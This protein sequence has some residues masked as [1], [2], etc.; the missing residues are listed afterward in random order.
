M[1]QTYHLG[2]I[3]YPVRYSLSP[4]IHQAALQALGMSGDYRLFAV[5]P[6]PAG[7]DKLA[8][9]LE[10][11]RAGCLHGL[12]VTIPH[13]QTIIPYLD[14]L[15]SLACAIGAV[16][17]VCKRG[18]QVIGFNTDAP[19]FLLDL[20]KKYR[21]LWDDE[22]RHALILGA[23]GAARAVAFALLATGWQVSIA[24]RRHSQAETLCQAM[25][26][27]FSEAFQ[28]IQD[29]EECSWVRHELSFPCRDLRSH[30]MVQAVGLNKLPLSLT[31]P[32]RLIVNA[33]PLG[34]KSYLNQ[35]PLP[36][37]FDFPQGTVV[38]D[39]VYNPLETIL[40]R[41]AKARGAIALSGIG[42]LVE[43]AALS[44][45]LWTGVS[46]PREPMYQA[47]QPSI[48]FSKE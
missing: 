14:S 26:N 12:N 1:E 9:I 5:E 4:T 38:Y 3:G 2:L 25:V 35:S 41:Q 37:S 7:Q 42:M 8:E 17:T 31:P 29:L 32:P 39:L 24:A 18:D 40:M 20:W 45:E 28:P 16:N 10:Q 22:N 48:Q 47:V 33:T 23:G 27:H 21:S 36:E 11:L 6:L 19:G 46:A 43:Q 30:R 15:S 34:M 44:F 13:K